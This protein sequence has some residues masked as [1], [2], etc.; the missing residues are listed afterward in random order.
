MKI[1][2]IGHKALRK[3]LKA[4]NDY[5]ELNY[6]ILD[7]LNVF[8]VPDGDTGVN[9]VFTMKSAVEAITRN[10][11]S[12]IADICK[13]LNKHVTN[14]SRGNSGFVLAR[15]FNG[16]SQVVEKHDF[17][18]PDILVQGFKNG[19]Y[20]SK[21]SLLTPVEGTIL[22]IISS[23]ADSMAEVKSNN[24]IDYLNAALASAKRKIFDTPKLL[25]VLAKAG[26]VDSG[27]LGFIF[28]I[29]GMLKG[30]MDKEIIHEDENRYRFKPDLS[31]NDEASHKPDFKFCTEL[32]V[33]TVKEPPMDELRQFLAENGDSI[34]LM[35]DEAVLKLHIHTNWPDKIIGELKSFGNIVQSKIENM[36]QQGAENFRAPSKTDKHEEISI[37]AIIPGS[38]F[39]TIFE[40]LEATDFIIH[41]V[42]LPSSGDLL[43]AINKIENNTVIILPNDKNII[44]AGTMARDQSQKNIFVLPTENVVQGITAMYG[45]SATDSPGENIKNMTDCKDLATCLKV[46]KSVKDSVYGDTKIRENDYFI[47][48]GDEI[49]S[50]ESSL[51]RAITGALKRIEL[52][53]KGSISFYHNDEFDVSTVEKVETCITEL[54]PYIEIETIFG[55]QKKCVLIISVE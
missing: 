6:K 4:G 41:S 37:L 34:A 50:T 24:I 1:E 14:D 39:E 7:N 38:G 47:I 16:F 30:L 27:G 8:P 40:E 31:I 48:K 17:I 28:I 19:S 44:P 18:T 23:M 26:V 25:P 43:E 21:T 51:T 15:F 42:D 49:L 52:S 12:T 53:D 29:D 2:T 55:G 54:N 3:S 36:R 10:E 13:L 46:Y 5:L 45:F 11:Y 33:E 32:I 35:N 9:M 22:T 20:L